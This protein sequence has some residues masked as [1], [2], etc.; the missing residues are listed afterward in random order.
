MKMRALHAHRVRG[1]QKISRAFKG[2]VPIRYDFVL[3]GTVGILLFFGLIALS[4]ATSIISFQQTGQSYYY[5]QQQ[6]L[7]GLLPGIILFFIA[8]RIDFHL[9]K[10]FAPFFLITT[11]LL[12]IVV[13][14]P[15]VAITNASAKSW[16]PFFGASLQ[17]SEIA[18]LTFVIWLSA[19]LSDQSRKGVR[20]GKTMFI[21]LV[22]LG[23][24]ALLLQLQPDIGML[25]IYGALALVL[26]IVSGARIRDILLLGFIVVAAASVFILTSPYRRDRVITFLKPQH[27]VK[28]SGYQVNQALIAL[29]SGSWF[30]VGVG[31]SRQ[32]FY[33][34][35]EIESDSIFAIIG[36]EGG[37][38]ISLGL[39]T[40]YTMLFIRGS[41]IAARA[42]DPFSSL[43]ATGIIY[44]ITLQ[45]IVNIGAM[46]GLLPLTGIPL[47]FIS[48]GG[49]NL[50]VL[51][52]ATGILMNISLSA[53]RLYA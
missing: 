34:L 46:V 18:K 53:N 21:L 40:L 16:I 36:E 41:R 33:F 43:M 37:F 38:F 44:M 50:I 28:G 10:K 30:G 19:W 12:L 35:P 5:F 20:P 29:G 42:P 48:L 8:Q 17:T 27:D 45:V 13:L 15:G 2:R 24:M 25:L 22:V 23:S 6:L 1:F 9:Y 32:K 11:F 51:L 26:Y 14:I 7:H 39:L 49:T 52:L 31:K 3:L 4:S 47:P